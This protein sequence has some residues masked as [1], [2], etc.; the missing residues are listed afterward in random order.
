[1]KIEKNI[2][3]LVKNSKPKKEIMDLRGLVKTGENEWSFRYTYR[4]GDF[5]S[6]SKL[7]K[8]KFDEFTKTFNFIKEKKSTKKVTK[9]QVVKK[10]KN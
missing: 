9:K 1:M 4:D 10:W 5:L 7:F 2:L 6:I 3:E 8:V